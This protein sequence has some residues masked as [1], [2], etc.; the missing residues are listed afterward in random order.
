MPTLSEIIKVI[1]SSVRNR[2]Q[3]GAFGD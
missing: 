1:Y 3:K 2:Y